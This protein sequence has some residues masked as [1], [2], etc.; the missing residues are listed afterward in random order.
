LGIH[1]INNPK[2]IVLSIPT[3]VFQKLAKN[4]HKNIAKNVGKTVFWQYL[5]N[6][7]LSGNPALTC[8]PTVGLALHPTLFSRNA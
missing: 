8:R 3:M 5:P 4:W 2:W 6:L 1:L 7:A